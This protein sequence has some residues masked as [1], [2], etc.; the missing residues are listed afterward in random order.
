MIKL[1][2]LMTIQSIL[3]VFAQIFLKTG[4]ARIE[5]SKINIQL[6]IN[7]ISNYQIWLSVG[8]IGLGSATWLYVIKNYE[9]SLAYPLVSISYIFMMFASISFFHET[10]SPIRWAGVFVI[11]F[12][13]FLVTR[14]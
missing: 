7:L 14:S 1:I 2:I 10:I 8:C 13:V 11:M 9:L 6:F 4:L 3:L 12:G 5:I